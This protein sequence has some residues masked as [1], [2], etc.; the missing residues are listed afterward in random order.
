MLNKLFPY[1]D[2]K[3]LCLVISV[4]AFAVYVVTAVAN[5][6]FH[7][8]DE[9]FQIIELAGIKSGTFTPYI[10]WEY[11]AQ[12]RP[13]LQPTICLVFLKFFAMLS[14]TDPFVISLAMRMFAAILSFAAILLFVRSTAAQIQNTRHRIVFLALS[15][16]LW[17]MP[18]IACRF[19]SETFGATF[20]LFSLAIYFSEKRS[21][22][23]RV[24]FG[25]C[26]ALSFIFRY[27]M[28]IAIFGFGLWALIIDKR[29]WRY[30][31]VPAVSFAVA[32]LV[33]GVGIDSWFYGEFVFTP[34]KYF[35]EVGAGKFDSEPWW[36]FLYNL[37]SYPTYF[38]GIPLAAA[39]IYLL[40]RN[41]KNPYLWI[42]IPF[43][44]VHSI[45][46]HKEV[47]F[48]FPM[49]FLFPV[50]FMSAF[51]KLNRKMGENKVWKFSWQFIF[52]AFVYMNLWGLEAN[53]RKSAGDQT[54]YLAKHIRDNYQGQKVNIVH[55]LY[56]NPYGPYGG[57]SGFYRNDDV[58]TSKF[59]NIYGIKLLLDPDAVNFFTCRKCDLEN[60]VCV[61]E[62]AG[63]NPF[64]VLRSLGFEYQSQSEPQSVEIH[65]ERYTTFDT[66][67]ILYVFKYVGDSY[68]PQKSDYSD[69]VF[70]YSD[71]EKA[72]WEQLQTIA[73]DI[74]HS[75][76][77]SS[78]TCCDNPYG[79][80]LVDSVCNVATAK[81]LSVSM[82]I[83]QA[84]TIPE[85]SI[86]FEAHG[87][88]NADIWSTKM[89]VD[90]TSKTNQWV[91]VCADFDLPSDFSAYNNFKV[92]LYNPSETKI[93][94]DDIFAVFY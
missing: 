88:A 70:Y 62:F 72:E 29:N 3:I 82:W 16:L 38:V 6:G 45:I 2:R 80:T 76:K 64:D 53:M 34:Y 54:C 31:V 22:L 9:L 42:F 59:G 41:P 37:V 83:H 48:L 78:L 40:V 56:S 11:E 81:K 26:V 33:L 30:F 39:I 67:M 89:L 12:I 1:S 50:M 61:G 60:M 58:T 13:M 91:N 15:L 7:H 24:L 71:C 94:C 75:G 51:D 36:F 8:A 79:I 25:F 74:S 35:N 69:A 85:S 5:Y 77:F 63:K 43:L 92:Y 19:S 44:I 20:F 55:G 87:P 65:T 28:G 66:G 14:V 47:R 4:L 27:Q 73:S 93:Y 21:V 57:I 18:Y 90:V 84:D 46:A 23:S 17:Y 10:A 52:I 49:A 68:V 86:V 32:Y